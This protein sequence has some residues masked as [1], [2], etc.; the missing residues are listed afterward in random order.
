MEETDECAKQYRYATVFNVL[1]MLS[2]KYNIIIDKTLGAPEHGK[3]TVSGLNAV[4]K[5]DLKTHV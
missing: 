2:M 3:Y 1:N 5:K 4:D